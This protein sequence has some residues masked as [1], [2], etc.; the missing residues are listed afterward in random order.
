MAY[1]LCVLL[2]LQPH[3]S[4]IRIQPLD[5]FS[6]RTKNSDLAIGFKTER[7]REA[8]STSIEAAGK[9]STCKREPYTFVFPFDTRT[10]VNRPNLQKGCAFGLSAEI[11]PNKTV[12]SSIIKPSAGSTDPLLGSIS[13]L[14]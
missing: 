13:R 7:L 14:S 12:Q 2:W 6:F 4:K 5:N 8:H 11:L 10:N 1:S 9:I 3:D